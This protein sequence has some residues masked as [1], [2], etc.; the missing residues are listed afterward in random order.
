METFSTSV[1]YGDWKGI[2]SA[3]GYHLTSVH[4]F[5][6]TKASVGDDELLIALNIWIGD[7]HGETIDSISVHAFFFKGE[8]FDEVKETVDDPSNDPIRVREVSVKVTPKEFA[9]FFK[10][11]SVLLTWHGIPLERREYTTAP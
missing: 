9:S 8:N 3:D 2:A 7:M 6:K 4:E 11:F 5:F 1:Q 10:R